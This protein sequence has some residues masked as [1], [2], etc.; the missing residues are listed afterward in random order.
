MHTQP[1]QQETPS[2]LQQAV[3][4]LAHDTDLCSKLPHHMSPN[5]STCQLLT[6]HIVLV[7]SECSLVCMFAA[8]Q[9]EAK[10]KKQAKHLEEQHEHKIDAMK[11]KHE[12]QMA[13][14]ENLCAFLHSSRPTHL[15]PLIC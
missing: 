6:V 14:G 4:I 9:A 5:C 10:R 15:L 12:V 11:N 7:G 3:S 8:D 1:L 13:R 2:G